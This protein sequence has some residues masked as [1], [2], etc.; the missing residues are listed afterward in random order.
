VYRKR[1]GCVR[2]PALTVSK[3][4][5]RVRRLCLLALICRRKKHHQRESDRKRLYGVRCFTNLT[6]KICQ[7][8]YQWNNVID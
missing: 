8:L 3:K 4:A 1:H 2:G 5:G 6:V 7:F